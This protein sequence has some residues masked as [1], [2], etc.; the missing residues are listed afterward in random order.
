M[1]I[2]TTVAHEARVYDYLLGGSNNFEVDRE[3]AGRA[4]A[5]VGGIDVARAS[6]R[7]NRAFLIQVVRY[8]AGEVGV[9]QYL[10]LGTGIPT[11]DNVHRVAQQAAPEARIVYVDH[12]PIVL[13]HAHQLLQGTAPGATEFIQGDI[14]DPDA[15]VERASATLDFGRPVAVILN[16]VLHHFPDSDDPYGIVARLVDAVPSGS[17]V[18][19]SHLTNDMQSEEMA[20]L[21]R[22][23]PAQARYLFA[24]RTHAEVSRLFEGLEL[25][26]PGVVPIDRWRPDEPGAPTEGRFHYGGVGRKP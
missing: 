7:S 19:V 26:E 6:V 5:A 21:A 1:K 10:D 14:H 23:V 8:L 25:V 24:A 17:Y 2:D 18:A 15:I 4:G 12:D 22:S 9:T 11:E 13:A 20:A 16:A 3:A